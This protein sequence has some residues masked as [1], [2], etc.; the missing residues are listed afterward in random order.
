MSYVAHIGEKIG[1]YTVLIGNLKK[2]NV[3]DLNIYIW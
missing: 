1:A 3:N 2:P